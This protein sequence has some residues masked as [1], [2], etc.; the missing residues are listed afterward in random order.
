MEVGVDASSLALEWVVG[1]RREAGAR[2][3]GGVGASLWSV[4]YAGKPQLQAL[5]DY[6]WPI[7]P[8]ATVAR[9]R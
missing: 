3:G 2:R 8:R 9:I 4:E 1:Q 6:R 5:A 7:R